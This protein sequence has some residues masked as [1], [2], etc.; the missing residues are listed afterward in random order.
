MYLLFRYHH[1]L[2][3]TYYDMLPGERIV[4]EAFMNYEIEERI[5]ELES[6]RNE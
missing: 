2:P 4:T 6:M 1:V 5:E 3:K